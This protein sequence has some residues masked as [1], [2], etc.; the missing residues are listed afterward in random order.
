MVWLPVSNN[1]WVNV[2]I[3]AIEEKWFRGERDFTATSSN[4]QMSSM[5]LM[6]RRLRK[7]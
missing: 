5:K 3:H 2:R 1:K 7:S 6:K 4:M